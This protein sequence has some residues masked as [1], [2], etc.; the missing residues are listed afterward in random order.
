[1][2]MF[3]V[4]VAD[5]AYSTFL[6]DG[7][8]KDLSWGPT[9]FRSV[10]LLHAGLL[11]ALSF[12]RITPNSSG[13]GKIEDSDQGSAK[14]TPSMIGALAALS[15]CAISR[16]GSRTKPLMRSSETARIWALRGSECSRCEDMGERRM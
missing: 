15:C 14:T 2:I 4:I 1:M 12:I 13:D 16:K 6:F 8:A 10:L 5:D 11:I 3:A 9:L 7:K